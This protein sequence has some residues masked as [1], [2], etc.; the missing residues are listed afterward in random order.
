MPLYRNEDRIVFFVHIPKAGGST[1]EE[2]LCSAG[3]KESLKFHKKLGFSACTPQHMHREIY[4]KFV[5]KQ[6]YDYA[7]AV[8][9][10]PLDRLASEFRWRSRISKTPPETFESW[11]KGA[12]M[13]AADNPYVCD[14]HVRPQNEFIAKHLEVFR[15]EDGL[16]APV[17]RALEELR[18][19]DQQ[20]TIHHAKQSA[21][22][23]LP[24]SP[25]TLELIRN[26]YAVDFVELGYDPNILPKEFRV[27]ER[28][29]AAR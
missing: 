27:T 10:H 19:Q 28:A 15:L 4:S 6:F 18:L 9:R 29:V 23:D 16:Q 5:K 8:V 12:I 20:V 26:F 21:A 13:Q 22:S 2:I 14:N 24:V 17:S 3:A 11:A 1:I 25:E 7:F